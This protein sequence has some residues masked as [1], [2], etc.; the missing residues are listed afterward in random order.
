[1]LDV[2]QG[3]ALQFCKDFVSCYKRAAQYAKIGNMNHFRR[4]SPG[5]LSRRLQ[6]IAPDILALAVLAY[7]FWGASRSWSYP[8]DGFLGLQASG[9]ISEI[10]PNGPVHDQLQVGDVIISIHG[11]AWAQGN[12]NYDQ[13]GI[14]NPIQIVAM[15][16]G[17]PISATITLTE[18]PIAESFAL[19]A[20]AG[21][22]PS[23]G[24]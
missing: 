22:R 9:S 13:I 5:D 16:A 10:D 8:Y 2:I 7:L 11:L 12:P 24:A 19:V 14:G 1:M 6:I 18:P 17:G 15:R 3:A 23:S 21:S 4:F 20:P